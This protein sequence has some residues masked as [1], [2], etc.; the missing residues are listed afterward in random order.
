ML[1]DQRHAI[2]PRII[3]LDW[4]FRTKPATNSAPNRPGIPIQIGHPFEG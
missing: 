4:R 3:G 1:S 2:F